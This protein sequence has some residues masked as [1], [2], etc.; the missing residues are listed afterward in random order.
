MGNLAEIT[1]QE[2]E[3]K[4]YQGSEQHWVATHQPPQAQQCI[5]RNW[6][7]TLWAVCGYALP[8]ALVVT[9]RHRTHQCPL[10]GDSICYYV[11]QMEEKQLTFSQLILC[12]R[13]CSKCFTNIYSAYPL[14]ALE[15]GFSN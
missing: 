13:R 10:V 5:S 4:S 3:P 7:Y 2:F 6:L 12:A 15:S 14:T 9:P 11:P 1:Q 8:A